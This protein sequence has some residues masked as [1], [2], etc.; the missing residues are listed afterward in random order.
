MHDIFRRFAEVISR[1]VGSGWALLVLICLVTGTGLYSSFSD[2]WKI[3]AGFASTISALIILIFLQ[4]SQNH[5]DKATHLKLD[6]LIQALDGARNEIVSIEN[7]PERDLNE[8]KQ[9]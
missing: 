6:E 5:S 8:L 7:Q 9:N 1:L 4:K 2:N 3:N